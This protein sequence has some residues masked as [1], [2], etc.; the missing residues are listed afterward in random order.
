M[1]IQSYIEIVD[2]ILNIGNS[3]KHKQDG[4]WGGMVEDELSKRISDLSGEIQA[5]RKASTK[6][7]NTQS[8][9]TKK[10]VKVSA[11]KNMIS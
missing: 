9:T 10:T 11:L 8:S 1:S 7:N 5:F 4:G 3:L 2:L 6:A